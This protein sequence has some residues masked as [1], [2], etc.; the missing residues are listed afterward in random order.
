MQ[1]HAHTLSLSLSLAHISTIVHVH[2]LSHTWAT[3]LSLS[4]FLILTRKHLLTP[5]QVHQHSL[6]HTH[7][8]TRTPTH[9]HAHTHTRTSFPFLRRVF[10]ITISGKNPRVGPQ[11]SSIQYLPRFS[12]ASKVH[13]GNL[14]ILI[15]FVLSLSKLVVAVAV[16]AAAAVVVV[17][18]SLDVDQ[19][20][21]FTQKQFSTSAN[22]D[23]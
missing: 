9:T 15:N 10:S 18:V 22:L 20:F 23:T 8:H 14:S 17:V 6:A 11:L 4:H 3:F 1:T 19:L 2:L 5:S 12:Q 7:T 16:V 21:F 13:F